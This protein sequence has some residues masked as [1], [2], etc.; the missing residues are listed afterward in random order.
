MQL[1]KKGTHFSS[2]LTITGKETNAQ[3]ATCEK[4]LEKYFSIG[5]TLLHALQ[6]AWGSE[7]RSY[8]SKTNEA[9]LQHLSISLHGSERQ[10]A[11]I[12]ARGT[13]T[14]LTEVACAFAWF[15]CALRSAP[16]GNLSLSTFQFS[17][18]GRRNQSLAPDVV[19]LELLPLRKAVRDEKNC[20][21]NL[22]E[23]AIIVLDGPIHDRTLLVQ[24]EGNTRSM[25]ST[26]DKT[27]L[28]L[29]LYES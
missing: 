8:D 29:H 3:A 5:L 23:K 28:I 21:H 4:Y 16:S 25:F 22:F 10:T 27:V 6:A 19:K 24:S 18:H 2:I 15:C 13:P 7:R 1:Y 11:V 9:N 26:Q 14:A 20:W 17:F 12:T